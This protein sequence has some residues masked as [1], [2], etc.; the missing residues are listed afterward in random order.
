MSCG[1]SVVPLH[2][3]AASGDHSASGAGQG[4]P[5]YGASFHRVG[6]DEDFGLPIDRQVEA[7]QRA[8]HHAREQATGAELAEEPHWPLAVVRQVTDRAQVEQVLEVFVP[9]VGRMMRSGR[10]R[11]RHLRHAE[12]ARAGQHR[13]EDRSLT[14]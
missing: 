3:V 6:H 14:R 12:A 5:R 1:H 7:Q 2:G 10:L 8:Q 9:P 11:Q 13:Q 4:P